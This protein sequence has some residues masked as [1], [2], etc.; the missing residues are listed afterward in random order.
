MKLISFVTL[1]LGITLVFAYPIDDFDSDDYDANDAYDISPT[2]Q[3]GFVSVPY[4]D[5]PRFP[6]KPRSPSEQQEPS[7]SLFLPKPRY[8]SQ[9]RK[10]IKGQFDIARDLLLKRLV[11]QSDGNPEQLHY[12][13]H[14]NTPKTSGNGDGILYHEHNHHH[15]QHGIIV[16]PPRKLY[17]KYPSYPQVRPPYYDPF[18][19]GILPNGPAP[20]SEFPGPNVPSIAI[21]NIIRPT[22]IIS[23]GKQLNGPIEIPNIS[24]TTT[25]TTEAP[26]EP[27]EEKARFGYFGFNDG[28]NARISDDITVPSDFNIGDDFKAS[29][30]SHEKHYHHHYDIFHK[31]NE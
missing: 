26:E 11:K 15:H 20:P 4:E 8:P 19:P 7:N 30:V 18:L 24:T 13:F 31:N 16:Q 23:F 9:P 29:K 6:L 12:H 27:A 3:K 17:P 21:P 10:P 1:C 22:K 25:T 14:D 2:P 5:D 28:E